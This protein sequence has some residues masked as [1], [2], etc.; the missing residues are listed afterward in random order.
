MMVITMMMV[1]SIVACVFQVV[2]VKLDGLFVP[3]TRQSPA[4]LSR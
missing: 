1:R 3:S 2:V 4:S